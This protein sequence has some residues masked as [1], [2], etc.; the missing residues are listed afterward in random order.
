MCFGPPLKKIPENFDPQVHKHKTKPGENHH[1]S[2]N[3]FKNHTSSQQLNS[4]R[5]DHH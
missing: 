5:Q 3:T 4:D 2:P 1:L